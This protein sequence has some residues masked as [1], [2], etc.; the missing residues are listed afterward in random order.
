MKAI[1]HYPSSRAHSFKTSF[2][3]GSFLHGF[4]IIPCYIQ[5]SFYN[6]TFF[7][8]GSYNSFLTTGCNKKSYCPG[9]LL[10]S[11]STSYVILPDRPEF[12]NSGGWIYVERNQFSFTSEAHTLYFEVFFCLPLVVLMFCLPARERHS[13]HFASLT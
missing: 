5:R 13:P 4:L 3:E 10:P 9:A 12:Y 8:I 6:L 7:V 2:Q 1:P 11:E